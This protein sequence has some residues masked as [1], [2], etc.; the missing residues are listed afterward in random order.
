MIS[1]V[2]YLVSHFLSHKVIC[3]PRS[4]TMIYNYLQTTVKYIYVISKLNV[5]LDGLQKQTKFDLKQV[6][7]IFEELDS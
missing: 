6:L 1:F 7:L 5:I 3:N 2:F 4:L